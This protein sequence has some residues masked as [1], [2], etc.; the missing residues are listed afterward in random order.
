MRLITTNAVTDAELWERLR[1]NA[2]E[3]AFSELFYRYADLVYNYC[4]RRLAQWSAAEEA[5]QETF[6]ALWQRTLRGRLDPLTGDSAAGLILWQARQAVGDARRANAK[7]LRLVRAVEHESATTV[8]PIS[9]WVEAENAQAQIVSAMASLPADQREVVELVCWSEL[10]MAD[11]AVALGVPIGTV[12]S[13]LS[14]ARQNLRDHAAEL[15]G[16]VS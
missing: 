15:M 10:S 2:S 14:R 1:E 9:R 12:K 8:D 3:A 5:T 11:A 7:R 6:I 16:E 4:F 13:R